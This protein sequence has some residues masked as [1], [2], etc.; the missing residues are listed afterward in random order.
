MFFSILRSSSFLGL[1]W[2]K[3]DDTVVTV[4][5]E[6][7]AAF[8]SRNAGIPSNVATDSFLLV[9]A[10]RLLDKAGTFALA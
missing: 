4:F 9:F 6:P 5:S 8:N 2:S 10:G 3:V 1:A 7:K